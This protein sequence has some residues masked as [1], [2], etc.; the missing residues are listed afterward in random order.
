MIAFAG[1]VRISLGGTLNRRR[2]EW[3]IDKFLTRISVLA[4]GDVMIRGAFPS[5]L[6]S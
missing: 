2:R 3:P 6:D 1:I 4:F 5:D